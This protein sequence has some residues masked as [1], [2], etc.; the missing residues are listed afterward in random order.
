MVSTAGIV[1]MAT[2]K[3]SCA[4]TAARKMTRNICGGMNWL[5]AISIPSVISVWPVTISA[6]AATKRASAEGLKMCRDC[7][8][9]C[10]R[11][12]SFPA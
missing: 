1:I 9:S 4:G 3:R 8:P 11:M 7:P 12:N 5:W 10:Q 6:T 2:P